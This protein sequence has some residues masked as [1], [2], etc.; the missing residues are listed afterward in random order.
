MQKIAIFGGT[1]NPVHNGHLAIAATALRQKALDQVLWVPSQP[2]YKQG[3]IPDFTHRRELIQRA[4]APYPQ[5]ALTTLPEQRFAIDTLLTLQAQISD[6]KWFWIVGFDAF[7]LLPRWHRSTELIPRCDWLVAP[8][9]G[10]NI[11]FAESF[12]LVSPQP[13]WEPLEMPPIETSSSLVRQYCHNGCAIRHLVPAA[14]E[15]YILEQ[16]LYSAAA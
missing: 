13:T 16:G 5:F 11:D 2:H 3:E 4:I 14:V 7:R 1:F 15:R 12:A 10:E 8:R 9:G 6:S